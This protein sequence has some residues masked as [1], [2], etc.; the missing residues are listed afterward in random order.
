MMIVGEIKWY[1][2]RSCL[3]EGDAL[4]SLLLNFALEYGIGNVRDNYTVSILKA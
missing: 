3:K 2:V 1:K 4:M